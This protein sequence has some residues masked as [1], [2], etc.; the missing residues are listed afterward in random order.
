MLNYTK[1]SIIVDQEDGVLIRVRKGQ[2]AATSRLGPC[3]GVIIKDT[4]SGESA[5][6]HWPNP[7]DNIE[8]NANA[9][10]SFLETRRVSD[11]RV[12]VR[13]GA[14]WDVGD[15]SDVAW[16]AKHREAAIESF[17][18]SGI[19]IGQI[20]IKWSPDI[21]T[22]AEVGIRGKSGKIFERTFISPWKDEKKR[23]E[24]LAKL[25]LI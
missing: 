8:S 1:E 17:R 13:G 19:C 23:E 18:R 6:G 5:I 20:D 11:C 4:N 12:M 16:V 14:S 10:R 3:V 21:Y 7:L 9:V 2:S 25:K 15:G 24:E 22:Q